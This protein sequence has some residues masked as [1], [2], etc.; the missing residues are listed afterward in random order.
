MP[1][2]AGV[3]KQAQQIQG[4]FGPTVS[5]QNLGPGSVYLGSDSSVTK[6]NGWR[7][8]ENAMG[9]WSGG[10]QLWACSD[11][12]TVELRIADSSLAFFTPGPDHVTIDG[13][14]VTIGNASVP[15]SGSVDI[16]SGTVNATI[17]GPV[18]I[19]GG[20][21]NVGGS[22]VAKN[23]ALLLNDR[24]Q[25]FNLSQAS[26]VSLLDTTGTDLSPYS[27]LS[28][29]FGG[30]NVSGVDVTKYV[31]LTVAQYTNSGTLVSI[32]QPE[33]LGSGY[34][35][36]RTQI[37]APVIV[38][39]AA[40]VNDN[41][42]NVANFTSFAL[43]ASLPHMYYQYPGNTARTVNL[44]A[45]QDK[46][47]TLSKFAAMTGTIAATT[48]AFYFP[49][50]FGGECSVEFNTSATTN[51]TDFALWGA[52]SSAA[53]YRS[54]P[55]TLLNNSGATNIRQFTGS[56]TLPETP[57]SVAMNNRNTAASNVEVGLAFS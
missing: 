2:T 45:V 19:N 43:T 31:R 49:E 24:Q 38:V 44:T 36:Y 4:V 3:G 7:L 6:D 26:G 28:F 12:A 18:E 39:T 30:G 53:F 50:T 41:I 22:V 5:I 46:G 52:G 9:T 10:S 33:M 25:M 21:V 55:L 8:P 57:I 32:E 16:A 42:V 47:Y 1:T 23:D 37:V 35:R 11:G 29:T 17:S 13:G 40:C 15:I 27:T 54:N 51:G 56:V 34:M 14:T 48:S 20:T